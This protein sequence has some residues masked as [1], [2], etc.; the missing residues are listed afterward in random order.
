[1]YNNVTWNYTKNKFV[2]FF[3]FKAYGCF[4]LVDS[5]GEYS[6]DLNTFLVC[7]ILKHRWPNL[8]V[9]GKDDQSKALYPVDPVI[10]VV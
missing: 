7:W 6:G 9:S 2:C 4:A 1:M 5:F 8:L 10:T 3:I